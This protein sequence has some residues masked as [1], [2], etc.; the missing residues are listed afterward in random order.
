MKFVMESEV[1][2]KM[3]YAAYKAD[4]KPLDR[5]EWRLRESCVV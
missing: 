4:S 2:L 5:I 1:D 3:L